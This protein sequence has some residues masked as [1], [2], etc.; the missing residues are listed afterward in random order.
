MKYLWKKGWLDEKLD[1]AVAVVVEVD[2]RR[3][4]RPAWSSKIQTVSSKVNRFYT[5]CH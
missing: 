5:L 4:C 3:Q 1:A 2:K